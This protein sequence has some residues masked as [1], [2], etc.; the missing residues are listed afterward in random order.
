MWSGFFAPAETLVKLNLT[1]TCGDVVD[2]GCGYG[3]FTIPA[4]RAICGTVFAFDIEADMVEATARKAKINGLTNVHTMRRD[5]IANGTGL[6][7]A[8]ID[9]VMLFNILH[10][11]QPDVLLKEAQRILTPGGTLAVMHWNYDPTTP[12]GPNMNIRPRP[13]Q[14]RAWAMD[15]DFIPFGPEQIDLPPYHFGLTFHK[16]RAGKTGA[17]L[18]P[19]EH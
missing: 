13:Q 12:R 18:S 3:T 1:G 2:V 19:T 17:G 10:C 5:F 8:S 9:Y 16:A 7:A 14:C 11:E 15:L 4:A 6:P